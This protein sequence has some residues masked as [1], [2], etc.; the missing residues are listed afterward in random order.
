MNSP[1]SAEA[2]AATAGSDNRMVFPD[3]SGVFFPRVSFLPTVMFLFQFSLAE[4]QSLFVQLCQEVFMDMNCLF[5][6][7]FFFV[8]S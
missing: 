7:L 4:I 3:G 5:Q 1:A 6:V 8:F 2:Q